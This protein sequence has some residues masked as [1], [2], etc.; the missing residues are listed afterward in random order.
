MG[1]R[2][3]QGCGE[4]C[5]PLRR[6]T[7][8]WRQLEAPLDDDAH[9]NVFV[10]FVPTQRSAVEEL[11]WKNSCQLL[12]SLDSSSNTVRFRRRQFPACSACRFASRRA[13]AAFVEPYSA[14]FERWIACEYDARAS[15]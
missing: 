14:L 6:R 13:H 9:R 12:I 5:A 7:V 10:E 3:W 11:V 1:L 15:T 2:R 8:R 4:W